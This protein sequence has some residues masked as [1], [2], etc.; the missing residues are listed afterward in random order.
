MTQ[1]IAQNSYV[2]QT[3]SGGDETLGN[4]CRY[5]KLVYINRKGID[6]LFSTDASILQNKI[7]YGN[8]ED[9][10]VLAYKNNPQEIAVDIKTGLPMVFQEKSIAETFLYDSQLPGIYSS[11]YR[12]EYRESVCF[13]EG[14][15]KYYYFK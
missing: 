4:T 10:F 8:C 14:L 13:D 3:I 5:H 1:F 6:K 7:L 9:V 15:I 12:I 2:T 11:I